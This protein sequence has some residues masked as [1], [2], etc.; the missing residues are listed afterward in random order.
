MCNETYAVNGELVG[1]DLR[2][3]CRLLLLH[4]DLLGGLHGLHGLDSLDGLRRLGD[5]HGA[6]VL[7]D[8]QSQEG[9]EERGGEH[10]LH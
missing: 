1:G 5:G 2:D 9:E 4:D 6:G 8:G 7:A 3:D 10:V